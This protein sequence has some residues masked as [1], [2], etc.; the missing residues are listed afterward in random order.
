MILRISLR[1][2]QLCLSVRC[3]W[4]NYSTRTVTC[5]AKGTDFGSNGVTS[6]STIV[7][8]NNNESQVPGARLRIQNHSNTS[9][10]SW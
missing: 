10:Q 7:L 9:S 4:Y 6:K 2:I 3:M 1:M 8:I 5:R